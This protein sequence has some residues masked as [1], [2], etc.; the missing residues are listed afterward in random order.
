MIRRLTAAAGAMV[1]LGVAGVYRLPRST[2]AAEDLYRDVEPAT[3]ASL[4]AFRAATP[5]RHLAADGQAWEYVLVGDGPDTVV[6]LHGLSGAHDIWWQQLEALAATHRTIAVTYPTVRT[7]SELSAGVIAILDAHQVATATIVGSSLGGYLAQYL[8]QHHPERIDR[9]VFANTFPPND[10]LGDTHR[11]RAVVGRYLPERVVA[12]ALRDSNARNVV[13]A[14][15]DAPLVT[16][17]LT[18]QAQAPGLKRRLLARYHTVI[19]PFE[20]AAPAPGGRP[21]LLLQSDNDPLIDAGLRATLRSTYPSAEVHT[22]V[23]GGH[24]PYLDRPGAYSAVLR[25]FLD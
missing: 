14:S 12:A 6:F 24:F 19:E 23:G 8:L 20:I 11:L 3:F 4:T 10:Q 17:Y 13:P 1:A 22:F 21:V 9:A 25:G 7:L 15:H 5:V 16:A 2:V 18:E